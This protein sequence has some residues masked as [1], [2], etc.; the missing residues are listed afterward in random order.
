MKKITLITFLTLMIPFLI[1]TFFIKE[2]IEKQEI[3]LISNQNVRIKRENGEIDIV[4]F[5][6]YIIGVLAGEMPAKF[7]LEALKAQAVAARSY[8]LKKIAQNKTEEYDILDTVMN[9]VYLDE[10]QMKNKWQDNY[11]EY[12]NKL[13]QAVL[14][15]KG[16]YLTYN[17]EV[18]QAFFFST[19]TGKTENVEEVFQEALPYLRSVDSS[20]DSEISPVFS[21]VNTFKL[22][23]FYQRLNLNYSENLDIDVLETTSTG[24]IKKIKINGQEFSGTDI[25]QKLNLR[26]NF[27]TIIKSG[28]YVTIT[29]KGYGHGVGMSQYGAQ[30]MAKAGYKY[31]EILKHYYQG[32]EI[33]KMDV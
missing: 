15:T 2:D 18:I 30:G 23:E 8:V 24:R 31:D 5:E 9:Q 19:S 28:E 7:E 4:P 1:V 21:E 32:V 17:G 6:E 33:S 13:K 3:K 29:T 25:S 11:E 16:E 20:W 22:S 26:S 14:E 12:F 27:F 10:E